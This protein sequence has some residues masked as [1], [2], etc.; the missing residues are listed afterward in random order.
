MAA[1]QIG[2]GALALAAALGAGA[3]AYPAN[4]AEPSPA[5]TTQVSVGTAPAQAGAPEDPPS[6]G[7][8]QAQERSF[9]KVLAIVEAIPESMRPAGYAAPDAAAITALR[10]RAR[11][12]KDPGEFRAVIAQL[13]GSTGLSHHAIIPHDA[14]PDGDVGEGRHGMTLAVIDGHAVVTRVEPGSPAAAAG[15]EPG[16]R[17]MSF[18]GDPLQMVIAPHLHARTAR[19]R[20][21]QQQA[22]ETFVAARPGVLVEMEFLDRGGVPRM[23]DITFDE[24]TVATIRFGMLPPIPVECSHR[25][26]EPAEWTALGLK[27]DGA[28]RVGVIRLGVWMPTLAPCIDGAVD[29]LRSCDAIVMDLRGNPG[30]VGFMA[31]GVAGHFLTDPVSLGRMIAPDAVLE[32]PANPRL[33]DTQ[34]NAVRPF[35]GPLAILV[36][37]G[38][39]STSE[40]FAAGMQDHGRAEIFGGPSAGAALPAITTRLDTG[41]VLLY[42]IGDFRSAR[43][44]AIEGTGV[45]QGTDAPPSLQDYIDCPDPV[46]RDALRWIES[47]RGGSA[48]ARA[49]A[50]A[51]DAAPEQPRTETPATP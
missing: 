29:A 34:G 25:M 13:L 19:E 35:A 31:T 42:A 41:D 10:A 16:W 5:D 44:R 9:D 50:T 4:G 7:V 43:G 12:A 18:S 39:A 49:N 1:G 30:G 46:L 20:L 37:G 45:V 51:T 2:C 17:L 15:V 11:D 8:T 6:K 26:I 36:D 21:V 38:T 40:I 33:V 24:P 3:P 22:L 27:A 32:F 23:L 48:P 14:V 28:P 47:T